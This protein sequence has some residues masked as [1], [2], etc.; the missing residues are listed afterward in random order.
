[1]TVTILTEEQQTLY[2][3]MLEPL[4]HQVR[5]SYLSAM[6]L[7]LQVH[8]GLAVMNGAELSEDLQEIMNNAFASGNDIVLRAMEVVAE[9][10]KARTM[11][12]E[13]DDGR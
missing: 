11:N 4:S 2:R 5:E 8:L 12:K 9:V 13:F 7:R 1:M 10:D 6:T 3:A